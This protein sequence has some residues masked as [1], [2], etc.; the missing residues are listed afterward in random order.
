MTVTDV[1]RVALAARVFTIAALTSLATLAG[2]EYLE[3]AL[4]VALTAAVATVVSL[5]GRLSETA[6]ATLEGAVVAALT[7]L[8]FP[9]QVSVAPYLVIP[10]LIG[11]LDRGWRG[12][13]HVALVEL[14]ALVVL[15]ALV[16]G[17]WDRA[18]AASVL[19]WLTTGAGVGMMGVALRRA[20]SNTDADGSYRSAV[21]LIRRLE[22]LSGRLSGGLDAVGIA[23]QIMD[24]ADSVVPTR[25]AGVFVRSGTGSMI[26]AAVLRGHPAGCDGLGRVTVGQVLGVRGDDAART[27]RRHPADRQR[28]DDRR[29][30]S[31]H[32]AEHRLGAGPR[33]PRPAWA[34][35]PC[36]C[37]L[38]CCSVECGTTR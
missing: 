35:T 22:A 24:E 8:T 38:P 3:G 37:R 14:G 33:P 31:G 36:S 23:E 27:P 12:L 1:S 17:R 15:W 11:A 7:V 28:R 2:P 20:M 18:L 21:G 30:R 34:G 5:T 25:S 26:P 9:D 29:T 4:L 10:V 32:P 13:L 19:T 6:V 16:L